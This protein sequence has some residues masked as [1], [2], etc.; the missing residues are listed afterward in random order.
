MNPTPDQYLST[1]EGFN[2]TTSPQFAGLSTRD[3]LMPLLAEGYTVTSYQAKRC[4][5]ESRA[6]YVSHVVRLAHPDI[7]GSGEYRPE[8]ILKNG[9]DGTSAFTLLA[10][11][12]RFACANGVVVGA[13][14]SAIRIR[15]VGDRFDLANRITA[16][17]QEVRGFMP[18]LADKVDS[19]Q[20]VNLT[21]QEQG[22]IFQLG[23]LARWGKGAYD[24]AVDVR[25]AGATLAR[26][27]DNKPT[28]W[29][30]FNRAQEAFTRGT[31]FR[32]GGIRAL[33]GLDQ[34]VRVNRTLWNIAEAT[35]K[36]RLEALFQSTGHP[37]K[38][39]TVHA[40]ALAL[41]S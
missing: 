11:L 30:T 27:E 16:G 35:Y 40:Q 41:A 19:W 4:R 5:D 33:R 3:A 26:Y 6:P 22:R 14:A 7:K 34:S 32:R 36:G 24:R 18:L 2:L 12:F 8:V 39:H 38:V 29:A 10:G 20:S 15:H 1:C 21:E 9:N 25:E 17:A 28:L 37:D 31:N 13:S 23:A